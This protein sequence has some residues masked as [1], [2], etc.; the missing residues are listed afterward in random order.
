MTWT[1]HTALTLI[2][3]GLRDTIQDG[4]GYKVGL[5]K[6]ITVATLAALRAI[7]FAGV[8]DGKR[9]FVTAAG[10]RYRFDRYSTASDD[11]STVIKP[12]DAGSTGRWLVTV[13][14]SGTGYLKAVELYEG[15]VNPEALLAR[16]SGVKPG[17]VIVYDRD[18]FT[19]PSVIAGAAYTNN[20]EFD[21]LC[22]SSNL[23]PEHQVAIGSAIASE[24]ADD[25]GVNKITSDLAYLL[26]GNQL[27]LSP[28]VKWVEILE[29]KRVSTSNAQQLSDRLMIYGLRIRVYASVEL[30]EE[31]GLTI[32]LNSLSVQ[33]ELA[34]RTWDASNY[35]TGVPLI[36][37]LPSSGNQAIPATTAKVGGTA[38]TTTSFGNTFNASLLTYRDLDSAG[39]FYFIEVPLGAIPPAPLSGRLRVAVTETDASANVLADSLLCASIG[40][41]GAPDILTTS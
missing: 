29:R 25:P 31:D 7:P 15:D 28:G 39:N 18:D 3:T 9:A 27:G 13:S 12:N 11:G 1:I 23:R 24:A 16:L 36:V 4:D 6:C 37:G 40:N 14:T 10:Y 41:Y 34:S 17:C 38:V 32:A 20:Y 33:R 30:P 8:K 26:A 21:V 19:F 5:G 35:V 22:I 2:E